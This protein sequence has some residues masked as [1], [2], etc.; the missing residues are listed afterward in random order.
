MDV[1][2]FCE[3]CKEER[4]FSYYGGIYYVY[5]PDWPQLE[6]NFQYLPVGVSSGG[7]N[8]ERLACDITLKIY[9]KFVGDCALFF[10]RNSLFC[11]R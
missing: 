3:L 4:Q 7:C 8:S 9:D 10:I 2:V 6:P 11:F 5:Y 1:D